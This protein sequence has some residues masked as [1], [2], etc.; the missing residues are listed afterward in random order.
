MRKIPRKIFQ[1]NAVTNKLV[2]GYCE[3]NRTNISDCINLIIYEKYMP[4]HEFFKKKVEYIYSYINNDEKL[5]QA[6]L[7]YIL[8]DC[9]NELK[10][11]PIND[12][13]PLEN[14]FYYFI[15]NEFRNKRYDYILLV[16]DYYD[17]KLRHLNDILGTLDETYDIGQREF[18]E[19]SK[20]IFRFWDKLCQY[21]EVYIAL[22]MLVNYE[23][24]Y[25]NINEFITIDLIMQLDHA[26]IT[27]DL[28][29]IKTEYPTDISLERKFSS[30]R[31]EIVAYYTDN[32]YMALSGDKHFEHFPKEISNF[33]K[34]IYQLN[35][36]ENVFATEEDLQNLKGLEREGRYIFAGLK[37]FPVE[38]R[39]K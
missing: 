31:S 35:A 6:T 18:G 27:S 8:I 26:V 15:T 38:Y 29:P 28:K 30:L 24:V 33:Y 22:S 39:E 3:Y 21:S 13:K 20:D 16:D 9:I 10:D 19:R 11:H 12:S 25:H 32:A 37:E 34:K 17:E 7:K 1:P 2:D 23:N 14:I 36:I 4:K 5:S